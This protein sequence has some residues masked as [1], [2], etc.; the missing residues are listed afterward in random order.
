M[1]MS[2]RPLLDFDGRALGRLD[3]EERVPGYVDG[4]NDQ[5]AE[6]GRDELE[7]ELEDVS[8]YGA[9]RVGGERGHTA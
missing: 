7:A 6:M 3:R 5:Y 1:R 8:R 2:T 4:G 9:E